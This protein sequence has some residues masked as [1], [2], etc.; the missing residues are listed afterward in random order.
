V[1]R[2]WGIVPE[3]R[4]PI[5]EFTVF[6]QQ[7]VSR[8]NGATAGSSDDQWDGT[9]ASKIR[10]KT[11]DIAEETESSPSCD[12]APVAGGMCEIF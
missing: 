1:K 2:C 9:I 4:P 12:N 8:D 7:E 5:A 6:L 3:D 10:S 11:F